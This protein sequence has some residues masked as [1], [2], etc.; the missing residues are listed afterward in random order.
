MMAKG[1]EGKMYVYIVVFFFNDTATTEIYTL[2]LHDALPIWRIRY[3]DHL[4][5]HR[6]YRTIGLR[7]GV[8]THHSLAHHSKEVGVPRLLHRLGIWRWIIELI[9]VGRC[10]WMVPTGT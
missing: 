10:G 3:R 8:L 4:V 6:V 7:Q 1:G 9:T 2:S 5:V